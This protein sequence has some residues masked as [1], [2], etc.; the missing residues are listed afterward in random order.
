MYLPPSSDEL[1]A[2][3]QLKLR[4]DPLSYAAL[5]PTNRGW[6]NDYSEIDDYAGAWVAR[7]NYFPRL[8]S[9]TQSEDF[10]DLASKISL[11][12]IYV[13]NSDALKMA[14]SKTDQ[15]LQEYYTIVLLFLVMPPQRFIRSLLLKVRRLLIWHL[16][17]QKMMIM[18]HNY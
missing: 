3:E 14:T 18:K 8:F 16:Y 15:L 6:L 4:L 7:T 2:L 10:V 12:Y 9:V 1:Q 11:K 17:Y 13:I 5:T